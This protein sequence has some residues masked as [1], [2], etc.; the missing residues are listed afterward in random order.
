[1]IKHKYNNICITEYDIGHTSFKVTPE[2]QVIN[3]LTDFYIIAHS[4]NIYKA[5]HSGFS[6]MA[7]KYNNIPIDDL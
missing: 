1:M 5:S 2:S 7:A 3:A 6:I 4:D